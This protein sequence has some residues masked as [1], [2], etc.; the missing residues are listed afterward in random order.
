ML[1]NFGMGEFLMLALFAL[2]FFGPERLPQIGAQLG[3]WLSKLT[4]YS[5]AFMNQWTEE[6]AAVQ[7]AVQDVMSIR[8]EIRAAQAEIAATLNNLGVLKWEIGEL[9]EAEH[10]HR[11]SLCRLD[12]SE[13]DVRDHLRY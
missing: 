8:D 11:R 7:G 6:A 5:K 10:L 2:L 3:K 9:G 4:S 1:D 12:I 13:L